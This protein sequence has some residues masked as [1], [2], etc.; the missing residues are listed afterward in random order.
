MAAEIGTNQTRAAAPTARRTMKAIVQEGDGSP[1]VL[2]LREIDVPV[3]TDDQ[4]L[5]RVRAA[6][7]NALDYHS[8]HGGFVLRVMSKVMGGKQVGP[9]IRGVD[10]AGEVEVVGKNITD[11]RPGDLV[12]GNGQ[13]T[14]A[15]Y[16][17]GS[18][19]GLLPK[20]TRLSFAQA[21]A[22]GVAGRTALQGLRD[23]GGLQPGQRVL[24]YGAGGGVG[25]MAVQIA[26]ALGAHVTA[27]TGTRNLELIR[28]LGPD[29]LVD[30]TKED[31]LKRRARYDVVLDVAATRPLGDLRRVL[32]PTGT[33]VMV[34]AA[35]RGGFAGILARILGQVVR[36]RILKQRVV[37]FMAKTR[38]EDLALLKA[39][40]DEGKLT[41][42][43]DRE[44]ALS[45]TVEA[46]RYAGTGQGRA[47]VVI[48]VS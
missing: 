44:Y 32:T 41:P 37:M 5:V 34:G 16:A 1:D 22:I 33:L 47:K 30:Y 48:N 2:H 15:E 9:D 23:H 35:K 40:I 8:M 46:F 27:V 6:S 26:R 12:F 28:A 21:S 43:I 19:R 39:L 42:I 18:Q 3:P 14:F 24:I 45:E 17:I 36:S 13:G 31:V 7:I 38:R 10:V 20:P 25:T 11:L 29:E 4:V